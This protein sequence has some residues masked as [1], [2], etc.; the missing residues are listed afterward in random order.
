MAKNKKKYKI[1]IYIQDSLLGNVVNTYINLGVLRLTNSFDG[2]NDVLA[3]YDAICDERAIYALVDL[4]IR[5]FPLDNYAD[6][7]ISCPE[8]GERID[9]DMILHVYDENLLSGKNI[10]CHR[11]GCGFQMADVLFNPID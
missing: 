6:F 3:I 7:F 8:C 11:A 10:N 5:F 2:A 4:G 9:D 1:R